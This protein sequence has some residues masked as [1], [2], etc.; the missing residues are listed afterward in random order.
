MSPRTG[1][2]RVAARISY[3]TLRISWREIVFP[4]SARD[5]NPVRFASIAEVFYPRIGPFRFQLFIRLE[6]FDKNI[7]YS[8]QKLSAYNIYIYSIVKTRSDFNL[9][10]NFYIRTICQKIIS[11]MQCALI[12]R[13]SRSTESYRSRCRRGSATPGRRDGKP[14]P[15]D[16]L[17]L[18]V[19]P[20][21][22]H[23][24]LVIF[25]CFPCRHNVKNRPYGSP[26]FRETIP[27]RYTSIIFYRLP[28]KR[29]R[30][31]IVYAIHTGTAH[32]VKFKNGQF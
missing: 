25:V 21:Y 27:I 4:C 12:R 30:Y 10:P 3:V 32:V 26:L 1:S 22:E 18:L 16:F 13:Q 2:R 14:F 11:P 17:F 5:W 31:T 7:W 15:R 29:Q 28:G 19:W 8:G 9:P 6:G 20:G 23:V 24:Y